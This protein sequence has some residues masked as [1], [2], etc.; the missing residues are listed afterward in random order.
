MPLPR[1]LRLLSPAD[2]V[3]SLRILVVIP[4]TWT[5][6]LEDWGLTLALCLIV[7]LTDLMD[8]YLARRSVRPTLGPRFDA[9]ADLVFGLALVGWVYWK[10]PGQ[11]AGIVLY[12]GVVTTLFVLYALVS[13]TKAGR[14]L[15]LHLWTGKITGWS[16]FFWLLSSLY[17]SWGDY[18]LHLAGTATSFYYLECIV[19]ILRGRTAQDGRSAFF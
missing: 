6:Y 15:L 8:G 12:A 18:L 14:I 2:L 10:A 1:H 16:G 3:T 13:Y 7:P 19:Y 17:T 5:L 9:V 4:L 11:R